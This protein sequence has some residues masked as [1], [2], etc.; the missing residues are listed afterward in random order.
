MSSF[1]GLGFLVWGVRVGIMLL[2]LLFLLLFKHCIWL[3]S[4]ICTLFRLIYISGMVRWEKRSCLDGF[5]RVG[6]IESRLSLFQ[7]DVHADAGSP[8][9]K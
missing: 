1:W 2:F 9:G 3:R 4:S 5:E 6:H 8:N 7:F